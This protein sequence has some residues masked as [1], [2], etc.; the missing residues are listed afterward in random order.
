MR[1]ATTKQ[2][3]TI[4]FGQDSVFEFPNGL[5][6]FEQHREFLPLQ[7]RRTAPILFL[8]NIEDPS[9]CFTAL[10]IWV[11]DPRYRLSVTGQDLEL[12]GL[13]TGRQPRIGVDV[14]CVALLT[15]RKTGT[16]ANL[17]APVVVN[18]QN[19]RAV[20]AVCAESGYS[21][22]HPLFPDEASAC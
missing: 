22:Q 10:P 1:E 11:V 4:S 12:L 6:G 9:L 3:G 2:F 13:P 15:V 20:Q 19:R 18:L 17:L 21:H 16:T 5:P 14:L 8:Q 7:T